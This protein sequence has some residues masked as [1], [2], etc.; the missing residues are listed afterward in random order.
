MCARRVVRGL[1]RPLRA[2]VWHSTAYVGVPRGLSPR[3]RTVKTL[4]DLLPLSH[5]HFAT[6]IERKGAADF[7]ASLRRDDW[8]IAI[9]HWSAEEFRQT[10]RLP[11]DRVT[12]VPLAPSP[13]FSHRPAEDVAEIRRRLGLPA[14]R[15]LLA[16]G[17]TGRRKNLEALVDALDRLGSGAPPLVIAGPTTPAFRER[18]ARSTTEVK[19]AGAVDDD[20]LSTLYTA[21]RAFVFPSLAEGFGLPPL[22]AMACG[23]AVIALRGSAVTEVVEGAGLLVQPDDPEALA[24]ACRSVAD[25]DELQDRLARLG[26]ER[27]ASHS[28]EKAARATAAAYE[29]AAA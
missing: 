6:P 18:I 16:L 21:C 14:G 5:P 28:W 26:R 27:A 29:A 25:D 13:V 2:D 17:A 3:A 19:L 23:A 10:G 22:E 15:F 24:D 8:V 7:L 4:Y 1:A 20:V 12:V 9:S 11:E